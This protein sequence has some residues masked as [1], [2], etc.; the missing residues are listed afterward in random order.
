ME[1]EEGM[2][3]DKT[4]NRHV[5]GKLSID[6]D[7]RGNIFDLNDMHCIHAGKNQIVYC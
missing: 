2:G 1:R 4:F 7:G 6:E 3:E 5:N